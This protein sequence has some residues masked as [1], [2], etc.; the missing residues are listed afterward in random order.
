MYLVGTCDIDGCY[1]TDYIQVYKKSKVSAAAERER[2]VKQAFHGETVLCYDK[3]Y[4][5]NYRE[6]L[7]PIQVSK[8]TDARLGIDDFQD[9]FGFVF[10]EENRKKYLKYKYLGKPLIEPTPINENYSN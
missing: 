7:P 5:T 10:G 1:T 4:R 3:S 6:L 9:N 2:Q 8:K